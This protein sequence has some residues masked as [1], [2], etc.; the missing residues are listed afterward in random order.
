[1]PG[2]RVE[3]IGGDR[4]QGE[5]R[6][7]PGGDQ[8]RRV[9]V[10]D[11]VVALREGLRGDQRVEHQAPQADRGRADPGQVRQQDPGRPA[12]GLGGGETAATHQGPTAHDPAEQQH[13]DPE[14]PGPAPE[15]A[16]DIGEDRAHRQHED[17]DGG[18]QGGRGERGQAERGEQRRG[19]P[20]Q[21]HE[22]D[23]DGGDGRGPGHRALLSCECERPSIARGGVRFAA[24][25]GCRAT[26][27]TGAFAHSP[28]DRVRPTMTRCR[29]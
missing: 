17:R 26:I 1:M 21:R 14:H 29:I 8:V 4:C 27:V 24:A 25:R 7:V 2:G 3:G 10:E 22:G 18:R 28:P 6:R 12:R 19:R 5:G 9:E 15:A 20:V 16:G 23:E 11:V 13:G